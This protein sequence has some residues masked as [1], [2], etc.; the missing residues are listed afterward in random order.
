MVFGGSLARRIR[1][2]LVIASVADLAT[3]A[4]ALSLGAPEQSPGGA[5]VLAAAGVAGLVA[6]KLLAIAFVWFLDEV[7]PV[8]GRGVGGGLAC[9]TTAAVT[10]N[11]VMLG[12]AGVRLTR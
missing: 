4:L 2:V 8:V 7:W 1:V 10:W 5:A 6:L 12:S 11:V 9:V 3:T